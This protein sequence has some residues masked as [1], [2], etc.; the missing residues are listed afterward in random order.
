MPV[1]TKCDDHDASTKTS[2]QLHSLFDTGLTRSRLFLVNGLVAIDLAQS[3]TCTK[4]D[5]VNQGV[6]NKLCWY[7]DRVAAEGSGSF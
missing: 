4:L 6:L 7:V 1:D 5:Q 3:K 2:Y